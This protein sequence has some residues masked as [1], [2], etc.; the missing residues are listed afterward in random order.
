MK[1]AHL[2]LAHKAPAQLERLARALA[3]P[4]AAVFIHL[5]RKTDI[6][7]FAA[8]AALPGVWFVRRR[9]EV[10]WGGYSLTEATL[11][12]MREILQAPA[13]YDLIN[14]I[15][16]EDYPIKPAAAIHDFFARH[17][18]RSFVEYFSSG[19]AWWQANESRVS[20]Y[21]FTD[22]R[23]PGQYA[24][25]NVL[26]KVLPR[27]HLPEFDTLHGGNMG[28]WYTLTRACAAH[29]VRFVDEHPALQ[30][31]A[32]LTW[33]SDEYL[34]PTILLH[35]PLADTITN[36]NQ[37][38]IDWSGGGSN[39]KILTIGD[40]PALEATP[41]LF[42]RKFDSQRDAAVLDELDRLHLTAPP[43]TSW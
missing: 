10:T 1:I 12:A 33:G 30:R 14:L 42:A 7:P 31:F 22:L 9:F 37:R 19:S 36:D 34:V 16:G 18:G 43:P 23:F 41:K 39:P 13:H 11:E 32:R 3:H 17:P 29:A 5:D 40:L 21:H 8:V 6:R 15:S 24:V 26:N 35:S 38:Y 2:I 27:R 28:G 25:Q 4:Q 20:R